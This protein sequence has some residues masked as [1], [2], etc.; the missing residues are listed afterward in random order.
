MSF[1]EGDP[2][3]KESLLSKEAIKEIKALAETDEE[4]AAELARNEL[5]KALD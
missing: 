3:N 2:K 4:A 1:T 5:Q